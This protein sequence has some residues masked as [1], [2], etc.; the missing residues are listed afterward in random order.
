MRLFVAL[1]IVVVA[2]LVL[3]VKVT[4]HPRRATPPPE[5]EEAES[6]SP[7]RAPVG[8]P[9]APSP[10]AR[11]A[12]SGPT[13]RDLLDKAAGPA[14]I[15]GHARGPEG[16]A[17]TVRASLAGKREHGRR[18][19]VEDGAFEIPGL[20][21]GR[22]YDLTF[23][24][25]N[26]R[27]TTLRSVTAPANDVEAQLNPVPVLRGAIGFAAG[28]S[29]P[30]DQVSL[31]PADTEE[32]GDDPAT[33]AVDDN[34]RFAVEVPDGPT[35]MLLFA[36]GRTSPMEL[37]VSI[38]PTGDPEPVCLNPP[39]RADP[40]AGT[41]RLRISFE[42]P[43]HTDVSA[44][45]TFADG[46]GSSSYGCFSNGG[47][48]ELEALPIGLLF[49]LT[50]E[51]PDCVSATRTIVLHAGDNDASLPCDPTRSATAVV[52]ELDDTEVQDEIVVQ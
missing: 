25:P 45:L 20:L 2:L 4:R 47:D 43:D 12:W 30:Y 40:L 32:V 41:G 8:G 36:S 6:Q 39:C 16:A 38:P 49:K 27:P 35:Q 37:P 51:S 19:R 24:G 44:M 15:R 10:P 22:S 28:E 33:A 17:I 13:L 1:G 9:S 34:C 21:F 42:G 31:R 52:K 26:L 14:V 46:D 3:A 23:N 7:A 18:I 48:C 29:C 50:A 11:R 5:P